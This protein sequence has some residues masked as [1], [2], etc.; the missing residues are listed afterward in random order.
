MKVLE[1]FY[2]N[3]VIAEKLNF[4]RNSSFEVSLIQTTKQTVTQDS[5]SRKGTPWIESSCS[6]DTMQRLLEWNHPDLQPYCEACQLP[7]TVP[8]NADLHFSKNNDDHFIK[9][10]TR[11]KISEK[12]CG[13]FNCTICCEEFPTEETCIAHFST[14]THAKTINDKQYLDKLISIYRAF[15]NLKNLR[16][17]QQEQEQEEGCLLIDLRIP[18]M[19]VKNS[20]TTKVTQEEQQTTKLITQTDVKSDSGST[21]Y[22]EDFVSKTDSLTIKDSATTNKD[23]R[24]NINPP[25][26]KKSLNT[27][28]KKK[29]S[30][31][32]F[33]SEDLCQSLGNVDKTDLIE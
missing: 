20:S 7:L 24:Y 16:S 29:S 11:K 18:S 4:L 14:K 23:Q 27:S 9:N 10:I 31:D 5:T 6:S 21:A 2:F 19:N 33:K 17:R 13:P 30:T 26:L 1:A 8:E 12:R 32:L 3:T 22:D 15:V 25:N 28:L